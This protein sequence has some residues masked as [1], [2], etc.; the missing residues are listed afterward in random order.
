MSQCSQRRTRRSGPGGQ[1]RNKVESAIILTH[2]PTG[3]SAEANERRSQAENKNQALI[4][5]RMKLALEV[6][7]S[8]AEPYTASQ[9]WQSRINKGRLSVSLKHADFPP[10]LAE[11]IDVL[12][13]K[14]W[15]VKSSAESLQISS[16][17]L[18]KFLKADPRGLLLVNQHR[19]KE[20]QKPLR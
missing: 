2:E 5:L 10:L 1:H 15:D 20:G 11:A 13:S 3:V 9:C 14:N 6:R 19:Q 12:A 8:L 17:Q 16:S 4:R 18:I 7:T